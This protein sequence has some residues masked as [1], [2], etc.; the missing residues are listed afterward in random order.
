[1]KETFRVNNFDLIRLAA[2]LQVVFFHTLAHLKI[3]YNSN[4]VAPLLAFPGVPIFFFISGFLI[5][6]SYENSPSIREYALNRGLRIYPAL[7]V[8]T[9][10]GVA[11]VYMT[12]YFDSVQAS[13]SRIGCWILAQVSFLQVYNPAFMRGFGTG[14][15]NGSLW[16]VTVELQFYLLVPAFYWL[17]GYKKQD[18]E[19]RNGRLIA[20]IAFFLALNCGFVFFYGVANPVLIKLVG[21]SFLPWFYMFLVGMLVQRNF[22]TVHRILCG[23]TPYVLAVYAALYMLG[24]KVFEWNGGNHIN[25]VMFFSLAAA[26]FC[27]AYSRPSLSE[28][29]LR[30]NDISYGVYVYH[31]IFVNL[32]LFY[33]CVSSAL[34]AVLLF[35]ATVAMAFASWRLVEKPALTLKKHPL[36]SRCGETSGLVQVEAGESPVF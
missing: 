6:R 31:S 27:L 11:T 10:F 9:L 5:S 17:A 24:R 22:E 28:R 34:Y 13:Y 4:V 29:I 33:G 36:F 8:C 23:K 21:V 32:F 3:G 15:L 14:V 25:P 1:M 20:A 7:I 18:A 12:G 16:T 19:K 35:A 2:A 26:I 30:K